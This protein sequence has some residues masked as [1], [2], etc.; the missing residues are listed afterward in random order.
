MVGVGA[1]AAEVEVAFGGDAGL[2]GDGGASPGGSPPLS[3]GRSQHSRAADSS[4]NC[5]GFER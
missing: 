1:H 4:V 2:L 5:T 3:A